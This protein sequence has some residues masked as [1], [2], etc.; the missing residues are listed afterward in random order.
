MD[1]WT[2]EK[3]EITRNTQADRRKGKK[4]DGEEYGKLA[5]DK[6]SENSAY[7]QNG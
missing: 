7:T 3:M 6:E 4:E 1:S 5:E 2:K